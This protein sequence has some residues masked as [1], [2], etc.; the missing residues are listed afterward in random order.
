MKNVGIIGCGD[1]SGIYIKNLKGMFAEKVNVAGVCDVRRERALSRLTEYSAGKL[2]A[3]A[4]ELLAD[5]AV[6]IAVNLTRPHEHF[7]V[8]RAALAAGKHVYSE[9]PLGATPEEGAELAALAEEKGLLLGCAPDTFL[10]AGIQTCRKLIDDGRIGDVVAASAFMTCRGHES[11]HPDPE[12]YYKKG[13]GPMLDM[14]P[15]YITALVALLGPVCAVSG[16]VKTSFATRTITSREKY[17]TEVIVDTPTHLAGTVEFE[18]GAVGTVITSFDVH[19]AQLPKIEIYGS[20]GTLSVPD[21]NTFGGPVKLYLPQDGAFR[22]QPLL[23]R[24]CENS[25]GLGVYDMVC[26]ME[27]GSPLRVG[28][29]LALHALE[30]MTGFERSYNSGKY[31]QLGAKPPRPA[32]LEALLA[33]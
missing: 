23:Y 32:P 3:S 2:Y 20:E 14:G 22:E 31:V 24:Y 13:G 5:P 9:K 27:D 7:A 30:V 11:W 10:G 12:F 25:R 4:E 8:T 26:H 15:Y 28:A 18:C 21:P 29:P 6:D 16:V 33:T 1:I 19:A 17:G